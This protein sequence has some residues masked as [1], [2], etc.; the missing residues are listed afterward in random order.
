[1]ADVITAA[2]VRDVS[3]TVTVRVLTPPPPIARADAAPE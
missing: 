2:N 3:P 1:M